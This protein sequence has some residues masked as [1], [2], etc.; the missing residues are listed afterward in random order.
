[1]SWLVKAFL[2]SQFVV[3]LFIALHDWIPLGRLNNLE[4]IR[5]VDTTRKLFLCDRAEYAALRDRFCRKCVLLSKR[6][7]DVA[8]V[9]ALDQ[10]WLWFVR[11]AGRVVGTLL[12]GRRPRT[13]RAL[14]RKVRAYACVSTD[15]QRNKTRHAARMLSCSFSRVLL[16]LLWCSDVFRGAPFCSP[17]SKFGSLTQPACAVKPHRFRPSSHE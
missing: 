5:A 7:S 16:V 4:K 2:V 3:V 17:D 13:S 15:T 8:D 9:V 6:I 12:A 10:L 1:M 11:H 14:P